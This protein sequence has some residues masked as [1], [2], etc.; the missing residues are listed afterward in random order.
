MPDRGISPRPTGGCFS[1]A[2]GVLADGGLPRAMRWEL[3]PASQPPFRWGRNYSHQCTTIPVLRWL[4][5]ACQSAREGQASTFGQLS[6]A[7]PDCIPRRGRSPRRT[8]SCRPPDKARQTQPLEPIL[9]PKLWIQ[10]ADFPYLHC[11]IN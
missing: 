1:I 10:F 5:V 2:M 6:P 9:V 4:F 3:P 7:L 11:S 8:R